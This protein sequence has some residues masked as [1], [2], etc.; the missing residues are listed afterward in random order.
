MKPC[1]SENGR[2]SQR[3]P[4]GRVWRGTAERPAPALKFY[5]HAPTPSGSVWRSKCIKVCWPL[6]T[7][8][9]TSILASEP[10]CSLGLDESQV[11]LVL[12]QVP[13]KTVSRKPGWLLGFTALWAW[14][15][16]QYR[17][18]GG[19]VSRVNRL[20]LFAWNLQCLQ[21]KLEQVLFPPLDSLSL[22]I[23]RSLRSRR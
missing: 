10:I 1:P 18:R 12:A 3:R 8:A 6:I 4:T 9:S 20:Y 14:R 17:T 11:T 22:S 2:P 5:N 16:F 13:I 7:S 23:A 15:C 21:P 19:L